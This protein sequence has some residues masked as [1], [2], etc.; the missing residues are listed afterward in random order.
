MPGTASGEIT[1]LKPAKEPNWL[2]LMLRPFDCHSQ[3]DDSIHLDPPPGL[4]ILQPRPAVPRNR[5]A[6]GGAGRDQAGKEASRSPLPGEG[7]ARVRPRI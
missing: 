1:D 2:G 5:A 6:P 3:T 4:A 7:I